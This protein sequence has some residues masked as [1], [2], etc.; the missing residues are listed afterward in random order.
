V[1]GGLNVNFTVID[2][3]EMLP[4]GQDWLT[5]QLRMFKADFYFASVTL[6]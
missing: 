6:P 4:I 5:L 2:T 3:V 1:Y